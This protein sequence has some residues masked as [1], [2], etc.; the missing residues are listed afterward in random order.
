MAG[1]R[2]LSTVFLVVLID[3]M[4]FGIVLP[5]LPFYAEKFHASPVS[6]GLLYSVYSVA[7][8]I[9]APLWGSLSDRIGRKPVMLAS[10]FGSFSAYLLFAFSGSFALLLVSRALAGMMGGNISAAQATITDITPPAERTKGM[11]L[12]GA[13][14]GIGFTLGPALAAILVH[15]RFADLAGARF[16]EVI[17]LNRYALPGLFA[18]LLSSV[19]FLMVFFLL[20]ESHPASA[21]SAQSAKRYGPL[22]SRF[23][24][25]LGTGPN[26]RLGPLFLAAFLLALGHSSLYS[27]FPLFCSGTLGFSA[28][29]VGMQFAM[30]GVLAVVIQG[31][32]IRPLEKRF[33]ETALFVVGGIAMASGMALI[34]AARSPQLLT[35]FLVIMA[36]GGSLNGPTLNSMLSKNT[37]ADRVGA[38][39]GAAQGLSALG[40]AIGPTWG[41]LLFAI[42]PSLPFVLTALFVLSTATLAAKRHFLVK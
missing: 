25:D 27:A 37:D 3:L 31:G 23:W 38:T 34:P 40:R 16:T 8:L 19:S 28:A 7:Q 18:A 15:P 35:G 22:T 20:P 9:F 24:R 6:I 41:G 39:M 5:L 13:A 17:A 26:R 33:G 2:S 14:F 42:A 10:T 32:M 21:R 30:M 4:G 11:G 36:V 12:L 1:N 29:Q